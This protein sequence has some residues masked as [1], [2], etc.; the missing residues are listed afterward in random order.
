MNKK[1]R[2]IGLSQTHF[3]TPNGL[4][5]DGHYSTASDMCRLAAY[6]VR[7]KDF[8][9]LVQTKSHT[10]TDI[11]GKHRYSLSN[12]DAFLS[13]YEGALGIK[14][15][16]TNKAGYCFVGAAGRPGITLTSC[17]LA[18][19]W[20]PNKSYKWVDTKSLMDY[21]SDNFYRQNFPCRI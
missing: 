14:T 10:F 17:V 18:C 13:Y 1:A 15:G 7:N 11:S 4:D 9:S 3:V 6:A 16:F 2:E 8:L 20:P 5:A 12:K 19:G 21:G